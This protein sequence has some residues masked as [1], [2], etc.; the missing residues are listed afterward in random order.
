MNNL[1]IEGINRNNMSQQKLI[2]IENYLRCKYKMKISNV[3]RKGDNETVIVVKS[4]L[5]ENIY[6]L[7][8]IT[9]EINNMIK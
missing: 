6:N 2:I 4:N 5:S 1:F 9:R 8:E 3:I 7:Q